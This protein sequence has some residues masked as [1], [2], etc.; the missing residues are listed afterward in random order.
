MAIVSLMNTIKTK[1]SLEQLALKTSHIKMNL[2]DLKTVLKPMRGV[3][4]LSDLKL[5]V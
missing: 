1:E 2:K 5:D 3:H 4:R